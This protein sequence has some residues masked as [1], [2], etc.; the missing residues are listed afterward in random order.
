MHRNRGA[1]H[2]FTG[3]R[4]LFVSPAR[5]AVRE[6]SVAR[7]PGPVLSV[8]NRADKS[9]AGRPCVPEANRPTGST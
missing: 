8:L 2:A 6:P 4:P 5:R 3:C 7:L 1:S 9:R